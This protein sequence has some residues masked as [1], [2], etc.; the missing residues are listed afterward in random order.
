MDRRSFLASS[1]AV[2]GAAAFGKAKGCQDPAVRPLPTSRPGRTPNT[3]FAVNCEMWWTDRPFLER[4]REA[5]AFGYPAIEFWP[6]RNKDLP[7]VAELCGELELEV[8][9]FTAWG[10]TPG[11]NDP[12]NH[13]RF[14]AEIDASCE[15]AAV[16]RCRKMTVVGGNDRDGI[17]PRAMHDAIVA[18]LQRVAK[19]VEDAGVT[20]IL[21]PMNVRVD[22]PG[23]C[24]Y[25]S[26]PAIAICERVGSPNV[27]INWDLY[28]MQITEG[29]L[30]RRLQQGFAQVGYLQ[31][32]D[33]P[34][35]NEPGTGEVAWA[36]VLRA[37][38][39]LGYDDYVGLECR[40]LEGE[41]R[42]AERILAADTW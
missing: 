29:D 41:A 30:C 14:A 26:A 22:H 1:A 37:A 42:A 33:N 27:K 15:A 32:A 17:E 36:R 8:A 38:R 19:T 9:Q 34:G 4:L 24:L 10:F 16:L 18:G 21:E 40:P 3:R 11:L 6:W 23:H 25:G 39:E 2:S 20:L 12:A 13:D 7:A 5:A 28:H 31:V 35:R